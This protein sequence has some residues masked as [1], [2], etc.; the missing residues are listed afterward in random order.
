VSAAVI[1]TMLPDGPEVEEVVLGP[2]GILEGCRPGSLIV[3]MSSINPLVSR[4]IVAACAVKVRI[5]RPAST[6]DSS[7]KFPWE[8]RIRLLQ[9]NE[10]GDLVN[11]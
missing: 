5:C 7:C 10:Q 8:S 1:F 4:K 3:D 11:Q 9:G 6:K 2:D